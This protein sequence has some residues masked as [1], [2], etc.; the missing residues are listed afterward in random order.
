MIAEAEERHS[1]VRS[2]LQL[3]AWVNA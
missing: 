2:H 3:G 1:L